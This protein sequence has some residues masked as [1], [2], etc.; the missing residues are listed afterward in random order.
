MKLS[1]ETLEFLADELEHLLC[2]C[3]LTETQENELEQFMTLLDKGKAFQ[4]N[5]QT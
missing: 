4:L 3:D 1:K 5:P 2:E